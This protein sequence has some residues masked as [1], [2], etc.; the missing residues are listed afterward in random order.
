[1][2]SGCPTIVLWAEGQLESQF[3]LK[4]DLGLCQSEH[5]PNPIG[6]AISLGVSSEACLP[7]HGSCFMEQLPSWDIDCH[8]CQLSE[9]PSKSSYSPRHRAKMLM[10]LWYRCRSICCEIFFFKSLNCY[11]FFYANFLHYGLWLFLFVHK[12]VLVDGQLFK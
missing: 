10:E 12:S 2:N 9:M 1:M 5:V 8:N 6:K 11:F 4:G 7:C 3:Y